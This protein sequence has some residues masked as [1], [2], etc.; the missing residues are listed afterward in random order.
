MKILSRVL[1]VASFAA[2]TACNST[3]ITRTDGPF[4]D[5]HGISVPVPPPSLTAAPVQFVEISGSLGISMPKD[6]TR[7]YLFEGTS[8]RGYFVYPDDV[9]NFLFEGVELDLNDN[10]LEVWYEEPGEDGRSSEHSFFVASIAADDQSVLAMQWNG[11][12]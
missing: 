6:M 4:I 5:E 10:C 12:C 7:A 9:G 8:G 3:I 2:V 1:L 11:G